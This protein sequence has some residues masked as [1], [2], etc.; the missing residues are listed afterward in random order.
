MRKYVLSRVQKIKLIY[1]LTFGIARLYIPLG[2]VKIKNRV[3]SLYSTYYVV[4]QEY[5]TLL[6]N[7]FVYA[8]SNVCDSLCDKTP[9]EESTWWFRHGYVM[10]STQNSGM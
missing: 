2:L 7:V 4:Q 6:N 1:A 5:V 3:P 10:I 8:E 9:N